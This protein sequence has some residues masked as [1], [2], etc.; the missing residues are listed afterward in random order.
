MR[1]TEAPLVIITTNDERDLPNAFLRRCVVTSLHR[2]SHQRLVDIASA[3]FGSDPASLYDVIAD[4]LEE[5]AV[6][7]EKRGLPAPS[8]AEYLDAIAVCAKLAI[9]PDDTNAEWRAVVASMFMK[10]RMSQ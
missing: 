2:P 3:H 9:V 10:A 1:A 8:T 6:V 4:V 7:K 5:I